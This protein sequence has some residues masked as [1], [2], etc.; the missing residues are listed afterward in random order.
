MEEVADG[1]RLDLFEKGD[2]FRRDLL[3]HGIDGEHA[4]MPQART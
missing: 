1:C 3:R 2:E 4:H